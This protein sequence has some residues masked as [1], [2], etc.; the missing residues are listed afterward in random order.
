MNLRLPEKLVEEA[1]GVAEVKHKNRTELIKEAL[2]DYLRKHKGGEEFKKEIVDLYLEG[3]IS[4]EVLKTIIGR[5][6]AEAARSSKEI[7]ERGE[8]I[9]DRM[10]GLR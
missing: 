8:E 4:Y 6:N 2:D 9:A 1:D 3:E 5:E 7:L 10:A